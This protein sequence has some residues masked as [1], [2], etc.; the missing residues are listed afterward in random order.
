MSADEQKIRIACVGWAQTG[1]V[2]DAV[3]VQVRATVAQAE[4]VPHSTQP[5]ISFYILCYIWWYI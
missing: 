4:P 3:L 2:Q 5:V 1:G